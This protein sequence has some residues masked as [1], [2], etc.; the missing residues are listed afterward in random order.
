MKMALANGLRALLV[1]ASSGLGLGGRVKKMSTAP[2]NRATLALLK[3]QSGL[4]FERGSQ[5][6]ASPSTQAATR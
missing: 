1:L 4:I 2:P 6:R 5:R 3:R